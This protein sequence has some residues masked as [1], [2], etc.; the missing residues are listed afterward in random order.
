MLFKESLLDCGLSA[1]GYRTIQPQCEMD[2]FSKR[3]KKNVEYLFLMF[4]MNV[5]IKSEFFE[6]LTG[7][8]VFHFYFME[9]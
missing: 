4:W 6:H 8:Y 3:K 2:L 7:E 5:E 1:N 9:N